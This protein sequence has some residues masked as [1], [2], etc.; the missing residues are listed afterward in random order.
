MQHKHLSTLI[1]PKHK[2]L[3]S[4]KLII[5]TDKHPLP[6]HNIILKSKFKA[7]A[8][9]KFKVSQKSKSALE[10]A[11]INLGKGQILVTTISFYFLFQEFFQKGFLGG[12]TLFHK[13]LSINEP[14]NQHVL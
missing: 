9:S 2:I 14:N 12:L 1:L 7:L 3:D 10:R 5:F 11:G 8:D 4:T 13:I 6:N